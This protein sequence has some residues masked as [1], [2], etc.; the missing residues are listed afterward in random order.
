MTDFMPNRPSLQ[1]TAQNNERKTSFF[2]MFMNK[3]EVY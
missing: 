3:F 1:T 2:S